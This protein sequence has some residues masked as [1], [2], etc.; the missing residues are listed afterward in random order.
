MRVCLQLVF[1]VSLVAA[2]RWS[3]VPPRHPEPPAVAK[4]A[5]IRNPVDRFVL[6][7]LE[8]EGLAPS[9][10]ARKTALLRRISLDLIGLPP[11]PEE[12]AAFLADQRPDAYERAVDR[13]LASPHFGEKW[14]RH[15]L[16]L[17]RYADSDG[18]ESD[19]ARPHAWRYRHWVIDALNRD[20]PFDEFTVEQIAGDL[21][22]HASVEQRVATGFHRNALTN[23]EGGVDTEEFRIAQMIDRTNAVGTTWLGL[24][25]G[26]AQCHDHKFDPISQKEYY[27]LF[28]FF[29]TMKE[30]D[31]QAPLGG[32]LG[33]Y[34]RALPE[35]EARRH[36]LFAEYGL[37]ELEREW[38]R[39]LLRAFQNRGEAPEWD[40]AWKFL[41]NNATGGQV[42]VRL[43]PGRRTAKQQEDL[44]N[45]FVGNGLTKM[46]LEDKRVEE[47]RKKFK[48]L[49]AAAPQISQAQ[50]VSENEMPPTTRIM[51]GGEYGHW[52]R[53][54]KPDVPARL[55]PLA[56]GT[57]P[58]RLAL[59]RWLVSR[60]NPLTARVAVNRIWQQLFDRG[61]VGTSDDFGVQGDDPSHPELLDWLAV[62]FMDR[63]WSVKEMIRLIA[64]S[65]TYRQSSNARRD[66]SERDPENILLARQSRM[67]LPAELIR[68]S[69]LYAAGLLNMAVGGKSVRPPQPAG[70][71]E[72]G[73]S[74]AVKWPESEG[75]DRYRRGLYIFFQR[76]VPYPQLVN[77]D[78]P[79]GNLSCSRRESTTTPLQALNLLNDPVFIEAA[80]GL[81]YRILHETPGTSRAAFRERLD[82]AF[83]LCLSRPATASEAARLERLFDSQ[84]KPEEAWGAV[85]RVIL[86]L[87][88]FLHRE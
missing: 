65:A 77:F 17:A 70:V 84:A 8:R 39:K 36:A 63:G 85:A 47:I 69:A 79:A 10:E 37:V 48:E 41:G 35:Y 2:D 54:V 73:Y 19:L 14:G 81:A 50:T 52:G 75:A 29:D 26:C 42:M 13:L 56:A 12:I 68:D 38:E 40:T 22:P 72:L 74:N 66:L 32:E 87:D 9:P 45:F 61:L 23:R 71:A 6:A 58:S 20:M 64:T 5:W 18:Y 83:N 28:A 76:T 33:P 49:Q 21:I 80:Q 60:Q 57:S 62:E 7:R 25:V 27:Q 1:A 24:T 43:E 4:T 67:Q 16:D 59:A 31:I 46:G 55:P 3:F 44:E 11:V 86:N 78:A 82:Y 51:I 88:E 53:D 30:E 15:W 34:L